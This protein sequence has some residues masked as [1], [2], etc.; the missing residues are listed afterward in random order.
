MTEAQHDLGG[1]A[2]TILGDWTARHDAESDGFSPELWAAL[3]R[4]GLLDA[5]LPAQVGGGGFGLLEQ[6]SVLT[7]IGRTLA[8]APYLTSITGAA[9]AV[10]AV[11][12]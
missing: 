9:A 4:A 6:C 3:A 5:A 2:R 11:G 7:E 10:A 12:G 1:L 8:P